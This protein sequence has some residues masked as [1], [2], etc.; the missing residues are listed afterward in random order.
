MYRTILRVVTLL[1]VF[2]LM[3]GWPD[4]VFAQQDKPA[5]LP[6][7]VP[8]ELSGKTVRFASQLHGDG[9]LYFAQDGLALM[10]TP[11]R[12]DILIG[13]WSGDTI[14]SLKGPEKTL[15]INELILISLPRGHKGHLRLF[16]AL[17]ASRLRDDL[18]VKEV[19][20]GDA[21]ALEDGEPPCRTCR[22]DMTFSQML[23]D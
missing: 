21:L 6:N 20:D 7:T 19:S 2:F 17:E 9:V 11:G 10:W 12:L 23:S 15:I 3:M 14:R 4:F 1:A 22:A 16:A 13:T 5:Y 18:G 8:N